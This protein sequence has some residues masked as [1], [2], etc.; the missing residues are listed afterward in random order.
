MNWKKEFEN[1]W[2]NLPSSSLGTNF[3]MAN[4]LS[5]DIIEIRNFIY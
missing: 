2:K 1:F 4:Q 3:D 5:I